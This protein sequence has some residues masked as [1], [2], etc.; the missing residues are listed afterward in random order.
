[1]KHDIGFIQDLRGIAAISIVLYHASNFLGPYG[2]GIGGILFGPSGSMGVA[3]FFIISGFIMV[4]ATNSTDSSIESSASFLVRRFSRVF[5]PYAVATILFV[6]A[7]I[8]LSKPNSYSLAHIVSSLAFIPY[9]PGLPPDYGWPALNVGWTLNYEMYFYIVFGISLLFGRAKWLFLFLWFAS[10]VFFI[11]Y[12][13]GRALTLS[14]LSNYE[15]GINYMNLVTNP[16]VLMFLSGVVI[17]LAYKSRISFGGS[18]LR[19][20]ALVSFSVFLWQYMS[21]F[22]NGHGPAEWGLSLIPLVFVLAMCSKS[23]VVPS[24]SVTTYLGRI[25][26]SL[27]LIHPMVL[28]VYKE[29]MRRAGLGDVAYGFAGMAL[30]VSL[31]IALAHLFN[32]YIEVAL[33]DKF[34]SS[35]FRL[36]GVFRRGR[37]NR[38]CGY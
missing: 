3:L 24:F 31:S 35:L 9:G 38:A 22:R 20:G 26:Y 10:T 23:F 8:L 32:I 12:F 36:S 5:P 11:P 34:K 19:L 13:T 6:V 7:S 1:M 37:K 28:M 21:Q 29:F 30:I 25:S 17:A 16:V 33:S 2:T 14:S 4:C 18:S 15:Y 27:Y